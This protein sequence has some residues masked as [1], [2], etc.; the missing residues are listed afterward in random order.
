MVPWRININ[1]VT[2]L[3]VLVNILILIYWWLLIVLIVIWHLIL[4]IGLS[5]IKLFFRF[6]ISF[7][8]RQLVLTFLIDNLSWKHLISVTMT[9]RKIGIIHKSRLLK[10]IFF[11]LLI[12]I[13][14][15][16]NV[17]I[18]SAKLINIL[19]YWAHF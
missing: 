5:Y 10:L 6:L 15:H 11:L 2:L 18:L 3:L 8:I 14:I 7:V 4:L 1:K 19:R 12:L 9:F 17:R 16:S 13:A